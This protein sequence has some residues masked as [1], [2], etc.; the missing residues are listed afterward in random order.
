MK[1]AGDETM[2][3]MP[4]EIEKKRKKRR[5]GVHAKPGRAV[6]VVAICVGKVWVQIGSGRRRLRVMKG[7]EGV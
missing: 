1:N 6:H 4:G 3:G 2:R 5:G 7:G